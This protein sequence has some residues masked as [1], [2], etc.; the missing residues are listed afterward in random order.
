MSN[1]ILLPKTTHFCV[2]KYINHVVVITTKILHIQIGVNYS[3]DVFFLKLATCTWV[4]MDRQMEGWTD[5]G[6]SYTW[7]AGMALHP[8]GS[9]KVPCQK[10]HIS[11]FNV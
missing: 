8:V 5:G 4:R 7:L 1:S 9:K 11:S 10:T 3:V 2:I 6:S